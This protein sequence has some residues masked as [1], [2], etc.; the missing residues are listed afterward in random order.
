MYEYH[1]GMSDIEQRDEYASIDDLMTE[2]HVALRDKIAVHDWNND[3][4][5]CIL[6]LV[7]SPLMLRRSPCRQLVS[8]TGDVVAGVF[9]DERAPE[10]IDFTIVI[11]GLRIRTITIAPGEFVYF[12]GQVYFPMTALQSPVYVKTQ[13]Y[14]HLALIY[15]FTRKRVRQHLMHT[16]HIVT[17]S[18]AISGGELFNIDD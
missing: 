7:N 2:Y 3:Y 10:P 1:L 18:H 15:G 5:S 8:K 6:G 14:T 16:T 12:F 9:L 13:D 11:T 4:K 17:E